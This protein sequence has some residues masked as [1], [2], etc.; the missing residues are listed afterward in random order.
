MNKAGK[1]GESKKRDLEMSFWVTFVHILQKG[2]ECTISMKHETLLTP[3]F[4]PAHLDG[5]EMPKD[6]HTLPTTVIMAGSWKQ[7]TDFHRAE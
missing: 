6:R 1:A 5:L 3:P 7:L 4:A 2:S